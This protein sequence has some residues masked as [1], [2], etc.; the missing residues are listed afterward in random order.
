MRSSNLGLILIAL[1]GVA[2]AAIVPPFQVA[3]EHAHF[4]RAYEIARGHWIGVSDPVLPADVVTYIRRYP[5]K[6]E[7][8]KKL[9]AD[10]PT[11]DPFSIAGDHYWLHRG[12]IAANVYCPVAYL[13]AS[14]A[15]AVLNVAGLPTPALFYAGRIADVL[16]LVAACWLAFR[17]A[18]AYWRTIAAVALLPTTLHQAGGISADVMTIGVAFVLVASLL[19]LR[20]HTAGTRTMIWIALAF[21]LLVLCKISPWAFAALLLIRPRAFPSARAWFGYIAAVA[22]AMVA[23]IAIWQALSR[24]SLEAFRAVRLA[25]GFDMTARTRWVVSHPV[26]FGITALRYFARHSPRYIV[27]FMSGFAWTKFH[28]PLA[29]EGLCL[30]LLLIV[31]ATEAASKQFTRWERAI[32]AGV[33]LVGVVFLHVVLYVSDSFDGIQGRYFTPFCL[34]ALV[35]MRQA[36]FT[37]SQELLTRLV[38][39]F[40]LLHGVAAIVWFC[41]AYY[42]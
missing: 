13:P 15:I 8:S 24:E 26:A 31:A 20:E 32:W 22:L 41:G 34:F 4:V 7:W 6:L 30:L 1:L 10:D 27:M 2:F 38:L 35:A 3:D 17:L 23:A 25:D 37:L 33:F 28:L 14:A 16:V 21:V 40:G 19:W 36:R 29:L 9:N 39:G 12:I 42:N 11:A 18:P 5:E